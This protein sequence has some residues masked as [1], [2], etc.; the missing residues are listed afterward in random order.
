YKLRYAWAADMTMT[1][2]N[3]QQV[4]PGVASL[5]RELVAPHAGRAG[6]AQDRLLRPSA[7][8]LRGTGLAAVGKPPLAPPDAEADARQDESDISIPRARGNAVMAARANARIVAGPFRS[9]VIGRDTPCRIGMYD[10]LVQQLDIE[11]QMVEI[12]AT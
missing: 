7:N 6:G 9:A 5:L 10:R 2:G 4:V 3:R 11:P 1:I 8:K 12:E